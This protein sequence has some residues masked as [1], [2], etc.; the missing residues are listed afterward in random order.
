MI[1]VKDY[2]TSYTIYKYA[3]AVEHNI[4]FIIHWRRENIKRGDYILTDNWYVVPVVN[5]CKNLI[6]LPKYIIRQYYLY[7]IYPIQNGRLK[8][9]FIPNMDARYTWQNYNIIDLMKS[10]FCRSIC[11]IEY[12]IVSEYLKCFNAEQVIGTLFKL[13]QLAPF[14]RQ[15]LNYIN[16]KYIQELL[17]SEI[18]KAFEQ[19]GVDLA[20]LIKRIDK[21][22]QSLIDKMG[23]AKVQDAINLANASHKFTRDLFILYTK[24]ESTRSDGLMLTP[25]N[26]LVEPKTKEIEDAVQEETN[27]TSASED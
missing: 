1:I 10:R 15:L 17:M 23:D 18:K 13:K 7:C 19:A 14:K 26:M 27:Y 12:L 5:V 6:Y 9:K 11:V 8:T 16:S 22:S 2:K 25:P 21:T 24:G 20:R 4:Q 3:E